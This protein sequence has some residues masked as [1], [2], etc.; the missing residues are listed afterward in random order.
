V[1]AAVEAAA[2][3]PFFRFMQT[4]IFDPLGMT[5][6][7]PDSSMEPV[8]RR[9]TFYF[10]KFAADTRYGPELARDGD[11]SCF[12]GAAGFLSTPS[13]LVRFGMAVGRG[14]LLQPAT[15]ELLQTPQKLT[16]GQQTDYGLGWT[17]GTITLA[18]ESTRR[19]GHDTT[20]DFIGGTASLETFPQRG[21]VVAITTNTSFAN[22]SAL[23][24]SVAQ[25]FAE[26]GK[27]P[28]GQ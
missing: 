26:Q 28:A 3:E 7:I 1:S 16:S 9:A 25:A 27:N 18:G 10:P 8:Q 6:T 5:G 24:V 4:Q 20:P 23:A 22:T 13:D 19:V 17:L 12:A 15:T 14:K 2:S 11:Y 21:I